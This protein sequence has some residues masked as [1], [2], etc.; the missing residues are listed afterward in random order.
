MDAERYR[1]K[2]NR[3]L[4][5]SARELIDPSYRNDGEAVRAK[6]DYEC[7]TRYNDRG[8][9]EL[10]IGEL[11]DLIGYLRSLL[12]GKEKQFAGRKQIQTLYFYG[13]AV[14]LTYCD[15]DDICIIES[16]AACDPQGQPIQ[17]KHEYKGEEAR[18]YC[19]EIYYAKRRL[20][21]TVTRKLFE[22]WLNP[23]LNKYLIEGKLKE[24]VRNPRR[25]YYESLTD[26]Q[27]QY[28]INRLKL[29]YEKIAFKPP[30]ADESYSLN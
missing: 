13:L 1:T 9:D 19:T 26:K 28:L 27:A 11:I 6:R 12:P 20:P 24:S 5:L 14:A 16:V 21:D 22:R 10:T 3:D 25:L 29:I 18:F 4:Y 17:E 30:T 23:H 8:Y 2:L 15:F 7:C